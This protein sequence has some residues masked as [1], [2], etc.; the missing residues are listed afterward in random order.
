MVYMRKKKST[1]PR[2]MKARSMA[3]QLYDANYKW[4]SIKYFCKAEDD[5]AKVE[6]VE[7]K[8]RPFTAA[9]GKE[10]K[11]QALVQ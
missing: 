4:T 5:E 1:T 6:E 11:T 3:I 10:A 8:A 7:E 9:P 2:T